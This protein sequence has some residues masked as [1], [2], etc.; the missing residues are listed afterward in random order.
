WIPQSIVAVSGEASDASTLA[1]GVERDLRTRAV[2]ENPTPAML[3]AHGSGS[4][5]VEHAGWN[6][7]ALRVHASGNAVLVTSDQYFPGWDATVD[8]HSTPIRPANVAMRAIAVPAGDHT[9]VFTYEP[10]QF[11]YGL[12]FSIAGALALI[13]RVI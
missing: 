11:R 10:S 9:V 4:A 8:G 5:V 6:D 13:A 1:A 12:L 3:S 7:L 2:V